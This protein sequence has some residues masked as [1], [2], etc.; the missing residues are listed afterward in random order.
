MTPASALSKAVPKALSLG[1]CGLALHI[2]VASLLGQL[3]SSTTTGSGSKQLVNAANA[4]KLG[5]A[6]SQR[7][8]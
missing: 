2:A 3:S 4:Q 1:F 7:L 5:A 8:A 6:K